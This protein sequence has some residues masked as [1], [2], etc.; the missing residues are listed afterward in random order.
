MSILAGDLMLAKFAMMACVDQM[1]V[2]LCLMRMRKVFGGNFMWQSQSHQ[3][4]IMHIP[5][6]ASALSRAIL[7]KSS[8][9]AEKDKE[10][11]VST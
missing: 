11:L 8:H 2:G 6:A 10:T 5:G 4:S 7:S 9:Y 1:S 3:D